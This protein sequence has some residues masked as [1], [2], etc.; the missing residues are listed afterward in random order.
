MNHENNILCSFPVMVLI[1]LFLCISTVPA[2]ADTIVS[3]DDVCVEPGDSIPVPIMINNVTN[4]GVADIIIVYNQSVVRVTSVT[5]STFE[6]MTGVIND[7]AGT[8]RMV[9]MDYSV[10]GLSGDVKLADIMLEAVGAAGETSTLN[11]IIN[12]LKEAGTPETTIPAET[13]NGTFGIFNPPESPTILSNTTGCHWINWTW[14]SGSNTDFVEV[15]VDSVWKENCTKQYYNC[16]YPPHATRTISLRGHNS[17]LDRYSEQITQTTT[18][19]NHAPVAIAR[20]VHRHNHVGSVYLSKAIFDATASYD[21]DGSITNYQWN[22]GDGI[23]GVGALVEHIYSSCDWNG[24]G[25]DTFVV[26]L[27]VTDDLDPLIN[28]TTTLPVNV[29]IA[30]DVSGDGRVNIADGTIFGLQFGANCGDHCWEGNDN[31]D[32]ADLNNDCRV[33]I[34]DAMILGTNWGDT[35]W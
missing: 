27:T 18:I 32:R 15:I 4:L 24:T 25:Y 33:N 8:V 14:A 21:P 17:S 31:G 10:A 11:L 13:D 6:F 12:E 23:P 35:A 28:D 29:Y 19:P 26:S 22:F 34:G 20:S 5:N 1:A 30:G 16:S 3:V 9:A 7:S 2:S